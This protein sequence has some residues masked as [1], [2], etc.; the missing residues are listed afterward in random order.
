MID[1]ADTIRG[2]L[3]LHATPPDLGYNGCVAVASFAA[4]AAAGAILFNSIGRWCFALPPVV[5][6]LARI[7]AKTSLTAQTG[8]RGPQSATT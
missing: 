6:L 2:G 5:A 8:T 4:G 3:G 7:T 1:I